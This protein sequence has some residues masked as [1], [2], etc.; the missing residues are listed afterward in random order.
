MKQ[1]VKI[2]KELKI[3]LQ[4]ERILKEFDD[5]ARAS[6]DYYGYTIYDID[7]AFLWKDTPQGFKFWSQLWD[8]FNPI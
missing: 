7:Q 6:S 3:V 2:S 1:K 5:N 8:K 4:K